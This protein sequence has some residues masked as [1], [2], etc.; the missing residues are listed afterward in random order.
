MVLVAVAIRC[1][2]E[3]GRQYV[4]SFGAAF[5]PVVYSPVM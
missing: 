1:G 5:G 2:L 3:A 4:V